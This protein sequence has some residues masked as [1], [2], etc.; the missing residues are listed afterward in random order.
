MNPIQVRHIR[1]AIIEKF[2]RLIDMSDW[3]NAAE[4]RRR[5]IFRS[6]ALTALAVQVETG[7]TD[8][9]A[10][11]AVI[12]GGQDQG[13]DAVA[14]SA[15]E[16]AP[17]LWLVQT[18]WA[19]SGNAS[20]KQDEALQFIR[21][22][23]K[24]LNSEYEIF[25]NKFQAIAPDVD[26][27]LG[28]RGV[29]ITLVVALLGNTKLHDDVM[30]VLQEECDKL[31]F[32]KPMVDLRVLGL[33]HF[34]QAILGDAAQPQI[35]LDARLEGWN[36]QK[37]PYEAYYGSMAV[38]DIA[39]W[40]DE[41][42]RALFSKNIRDS[43][44]LT[45]VN[46][47]IVD[48]LRNNPEKFWYFNNGITVLCDSVAKT[49]R[50]VPS[51]GGP[52]DFKI[53][54]ASVVNGAQTVA[55]IHR[56]LRQ[57]SETPNP[58]QV[59]VRLISLENCPEGF[60]E[61]VTQKTNTQNKV[62]TRDFRAL[63]HGQ[64]R[65]RED[66]ARAL[67][68]KYVIK[69]GEQRPEP[70]EGCSIDEAAIAL[71]CAHKSPE[72]AARAKREEEL[73]WED[74]T[75]HAIFGTHPNAYR[76]WRCVLV[77]RAV[78]SE[79]EALGRTLT[80]RKAAVTL[81]GDLLIAHIVFQKLGLDLSKA[82][83]TAADPDWKHAIEQIPELTKTAFLW[84]ARAIDK[85]FGPSSYVIATCKS[86]ERSR[87]VVRDVL[88]QMANPDAVAPEMPRPYRST[89]SG[90]RMNAVSVL[91]D[92]GFIP[93]GTLLEF[94]GV[95]R[96]ERAALAPWVV[97]DPKRGLAAWSAG[98]RRAPLRWL[99]DN[100]YYSPTGLVTRMLE[101]ATGSAPRAVQGTARWY[102]PGKGSLV[103]LAERARQEDEAYQE[104]DDELETDE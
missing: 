66:F 19:E 14:I 12:D 49:P 75:Y 41:H 71:A 45:D 52:G 24:I 67:R 83:D 20:L 50:F 31:N 65:L 84:L 77:L 68:K 96:T 59:L 102:W 36:I 79:L 39:S 48:T 94:R 42:G 46:V 29:Q 104:E 72:Y 6:R 103:E 9:E 60:G 91:F 13:I 56:A 40:Y 54:G 88:A 44:D 34:Y 53:V 30:S 57:G 86:S 33:K 5:P 32:A 97:E 23:Q 89:T 87:T 43:L 18:K 85:Q 70:D 38:A 17:R 26:R 47:S 21:G 27:V 25:N 74:R 101:L 92:S 90:R 4:D 15:P 35:D 51:P 55:A 22:M 61:Q 3:A 11:A 73:L 95:N 80:G 1:E 99:A 16:K 93:D 7:C 2:E 98:N 78:R 62:E 8:E 58:G 82:E 76:V 37:E 64:H 10:A 81:Y 63:E 100:Q 69:R 28:I